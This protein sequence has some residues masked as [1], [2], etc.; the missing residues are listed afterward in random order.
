MIKQTYSRPSKLEQ[1]IR[2][3][4]MKMVGI[5][6]HNSLYQWL[7]RLKVSQKIAWGY[8]MGIG[9]AILG[10]I[11]GF[12]ISEFYQYQAIKNREDALEEANMINDLQKNF[13]GVQGHLEHLIFALE[14]GEAL[15]EEYRNFVEYSTKLKASWS[16]FVNSM[17][18]TEGDEKESL[19][20]VQ[21]VTEFLEKYQGIP[22]MYLYNSQN[23]LTEL[24]LPNIKEDE[25]PVVL[26][27]LLKYGKKQENL[28]IE[29]LIDDLDDLAKIYQAEY[30]EAEQE[31]QRIKLLKLQ[32]IALSLFL[33]IAISLFLGISLSISL[34]NP[35]EKLA[36][37][38]Q[39]ATKKSNFNLR[40]NVTSKD[41]IGIVGIS[42]NHLLE[43]VSQL[44]EM[45]ALA[46]NQLERYNENL[47]LEVASRTQEINDKNLDLEKALQELRQIQG[48]LIQSEK[49]SSLGQLVA[50][51]AHEINNPVSFIHGN[52]THAN[53]YANNLLILLDIY[54]KNY[55][56]PPQEIQ[57]ELEEIDLDFIKEDFNKLLK[58]MSIGTERIREIVK[59]LRNFSRLDEADFKQVDIHQGIDSTLIIL[60]HRLLAIKQGKGIKL[61]KEYGSL[62]LV[63]CYPSQLNQV[64]MNILS[65]AIEALDE[66]H[67]QMPENEDH[68]IIIKTQVLEYKFAQIVII[69][70]GPGIK[71]EVISRIFDPFFT[72]KPIGKGTG[73]GLAISYQIITEKHHGQLICNS[74]I[75]KGTEFIIT[76]PIATSLPKLS[77]PL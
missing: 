66:C 23:L 4:V 76:L 11:T 50:G 14:D 68:K 8:G 55:P 2:S 75:G 25:K 52:L 22:E 39:E 37:V 61:I 74:E 73:L 63:S 21:K 30:R 28:T 19:L 35:L 7:S 12:S 53:E 71:E 70:N 64:F 32:I 56:N 3:K 65:N 9:L 62:P 42:V 15:S 48:Q 29:R 58:S 16:A 57:D 67:N 27:K 69:D 44:L 54:Q 33:S 46:K 38:A 72:T 26:N 1:K 47:E 31:Y 60:E 41:E 20:E 24:G 5:D 13:T 40:V 51:V 43:K 6:R 77:N 18:G 17:G 49:M 10:I 45:E 34:A 36:L 59:S